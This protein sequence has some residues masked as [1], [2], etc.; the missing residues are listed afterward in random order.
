[1]KP[2]APSENTGLFM[3]FPFCPSLA[4]YFLKYQPTKDHVWIIN[5]PISRKNMELKAKLTLLYKAQCQG[6]WQII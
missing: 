2:N 1:M 6:V 4:H 3:P 5:I